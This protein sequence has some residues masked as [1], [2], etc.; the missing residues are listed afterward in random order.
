MLWPVVR[1]VDKLP[2]LQK[3]KRG[4]KKD[5]LIELSIKFGYVQ[6]VDDIATVL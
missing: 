1:A 2:S 4:S 3:A 6:S 5:R